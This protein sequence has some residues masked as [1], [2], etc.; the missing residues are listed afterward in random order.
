MDLKTKTAKK[1]ASMIKDPAVFLK[2]ALY[3][4]DEADKKHFGAKQFPYM[5]KEYLQDCVD[6]WK[7]AAKNEQHIVVEKSRQMMVSW[8]YG[9]LHLHEAFTIPNRKMLLLS[10]SEEKAIELLNRLEYMY[11]NIPEDVWPAKLRPKYVRT[12]TKMSFP[13][14]DSVISSL[15]SNADSA[16]SI[17]ASRIFL[18]EFA[19]MP[20]VEEIYQSAMGSTAGGGLVTIVSTN[21]V[22]KNSNDCL[23]W[24]IIDDRMEGSIPKI[25]PLEHNFRVKQGFKGQL[26]GNKFISLALHYTADP[27]RN[28]A[29]PEGKKWFGE[30]RPKYDKRRWDTEM[31]LSRST[32]GGFGVFSDDFNED[33]HVKHVNF[34]PNPD[35][36]LLLG[37]DFAGNHSVAVCQYFKGILYSVREMPNIGWHTRDV[38]PQVLEYCEQEFPGHKLIHLPDPT[39]FDKGRNDATGHSNVDIMVECGIP[40]R[41]IIKVSTNRQEPRLDAV[42]KL[43]TTNKKGQPKFQIST[44]CPYLITGF[45]GAYQFKEKI[46]ANQSRPTIVKNEYSHIMDCIQYVAL[47]V[48]SG[49]TENYLRARRLKMYGGN[50]RGKKPTYSL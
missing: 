48:G 29:T 25:K 5:E 26:N 23:F 49:Q 19:F 16:R 4:M 46:Q 2:H 11:K 17:T 45:K 50:S 42:F 37:W 47:Y 15:T 21:P 9:A 30:Q 1:V 27:T 10:K 6:I 36:P 7:L 18:D 35:A 40:F 8:V 22:L 33:W 20:D 34:E 39:A 14:I 38:A 13:E 41:D 3:T 12:K 31:E 43:L 28:P 24:R 44:S 32:Y